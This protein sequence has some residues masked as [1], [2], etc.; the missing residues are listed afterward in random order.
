M[1]R[2]SDEQIG[3]LEM[4]ALGLRPVEPETGQQLH[5]LITELRTARAILRGIADR[6]ASEVWWVSDWSGSAYCKYCEGERP[7]HH[8]NCV[9]LR[10]KRLREG[11]DA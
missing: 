1:V 6:D 9:Y 4:I 3:R 11:S 2:L 10:A 5:A 8:V 7:H